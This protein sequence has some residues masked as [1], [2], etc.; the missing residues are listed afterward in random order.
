MPEAY[1]YAAFISYSSKDSA[2]ARRLHRA[3]EGYG[4]PIALGRINFGV[5][6]GKPNRVYP[7]FRDREELPAGNLSENIKDALQGAR[8]LIVICS[9]AAVASLWVQKEIE[10]FIALGRRE[11]IFAIIAP[12]APLIDANG[13]DGTYLSFPAPLRGSAPAGATPHDVNAADA[14]AVKD[15]FRNAWLKLIAGM[16]GVNAGAL[17]DRDR[18]RRRARLLTNA[19]AAAAAI[20]V[21]AT[22]FL[23]QGVWEPPIYGYLHYG[24]YAV[25]RGALPLIASDGS[26]QDCAAG[27]KDCPSMVVIPAGEFLMGSPETEV[28]RETWEGPQHPVS[29]ETFA[30]SK[31]DIT[32][33][34]WRACVAANGCKSNLRPND[35]GWKD[36]DLPV[37]NISWREAQDYVQWLSTVTGQT[38]RLLTE[39]EWEYAA[40]G[41]ATLNAPHTRFPWGNEIGS[42]KAT[43]QGMSTKWDGRQAS[44]VG[45]FQPNAFGLYDMAGNVWQWV[46]DCWNEPYDSAPSKAYPARR[47]GDCP[48]RVRRGGSWQSASNDLRAA[49]RER[50]LETAR[51]NDYGFRVARIIDAADAADVMKSDNARPAVGAENQ[52]AIDCR[53]DGRK[54]IPI[55]MERACTAVLQAGGLDDKA[56]A[57]LLTKRALALTYQGEYGGAIADLDRALQSN[58]TLIDAL[59]QRAQVYFRKKEFSRALLDQDKALELRPKDPDLLNSRCWTRAVWGQQLDLALAD[60]SASIQVSPTAATLDSRGLVHLRRGEYSDALDDYA[61]A[62]RKQPELPSSMYGRGIA[63]LRLGRDEEGKADIADATSRRSSI[64]TEFASYGV[65]P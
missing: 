51:H 29:V 54:V 11:Q 17:Q 26:F 44:P 8:S 27:S 7:I 62:L 55:I 31:Y 56:L 37:T 64:A 50:E 6:R 25:A 9:P 36:N 34:N 61:A 18:R 43:W 58:P 45:S 10:T 63:L 13:T 35:N 15:G 28:G 20:A 60:C 39:A 38:Y 24:R 42:A 52:N 53:N 5:E 19:V 47:G 40:R 14:R 32:V 48:I 22:L 2:F 12:D 49:A 33:E 30:A 3:L 16:I 23:T 46:E 65:K 59:S 41:A 1:K 4:I 21:F 57:T